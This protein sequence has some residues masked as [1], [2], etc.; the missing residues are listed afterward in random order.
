LAISW[1]VLAKKLRAGQ[2]TG[3]LDPASG[4]RKPR[5]FVNR[6]DSPAVPHEIRAPLNHRELAVQ[7]LTIFFHELIGDVRALI[8]FFGPKRKKQATVGAFAI[9]AEP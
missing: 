6:G 1:L 3:A 7:P 5:R 9:E 4:N 8:Q 2:G